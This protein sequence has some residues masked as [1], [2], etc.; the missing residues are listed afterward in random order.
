[1]IVDS[2]RVCVSFILPWVLQDVA[3]GPLPSG[4][5]LGCSA[6]GV[7]PPGHPHLVGASRLAGWTR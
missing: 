6:E 3:V 4:H 2:M 1:M 5:Q 7:H